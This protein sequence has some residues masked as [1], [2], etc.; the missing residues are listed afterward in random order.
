MTSAS[1]SGSISPAVWKARRC[2]PMGGAPGGVAPAEMLV[3][4]MPG[5]SGLRGHAHHELDD[6]RSVLMPAQE[7]GEPLDEAVQGTDGGL[8]LEPAALLVVPAVEHRHQELVLAREVVQ[9][10]F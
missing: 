9:Q 8:V 5:V 10:P 4:R 6:C 7:P 1:V 3:R 2:S